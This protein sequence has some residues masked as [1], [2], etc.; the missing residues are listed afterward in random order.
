MSSTD[1]KS[2]SWTVSVAAEGEACPEGEPAARGESPWP[3][4]LGAETERAWFETICS[5]I[6]LGIV[7]VDVTTDGEFRFR[8]VN[9]A[10]A[11]LIGLPVAEIR[12]LAPRQLVPRIP[13]ELAES[14][15]AGFRR[16]SG[17]AGP[18]EFE[19]SWLVEDGWRCI[20]MRL[21][22]VF[23]RSGHV[24]RLI[25]RALDL[26]ERRTAERSLHVLSERLQLAAEAAHLGVWEFDL[27][28][29][30]IAWDARMQALYGAGVRQFPGTWRAWREFI[31]PE[32]VGRVESELQA[33]KR[34]PQ[35][36]ASVFR[37]RRAEGDVRHIRIAATVQRSPD[38]RPVRMVG[39]NA[40]VTA[41]QQAQV[42]LEQALARANQLARDATAATEAKSD[43]IASMSH[44][45]RTPMN[46]VIGMAGL[47][48]A[49]PLTPEQREFAE[50]IRASGDG[51]LALLNDLLDYAKIEAGRL[52]LEQRPFRV[53]DCMEASLDVLAARAAEK[54]LELV[55][56][57]EKGVPELVV[58][59]E[60]RLRQVVLNLLSNAVKFTMEGE[61]FL[62]LSLVGGTRE[63]ARLRCAV[64]DSGIGIPPDRMDRL[65]RSFSQVDASTTR[66][67][68]GTGLGLAISKRLVELMGGRIWVESTPGKGSIFYFEWETSAVAAADSEALAPGALTARRVLVVDDNATCARVLCQQAVAW[69]MVP[70]A[71]GSLRE[72]VGVL[73]R[74]E[75]FDL[76]LLDADLIRAAESEAAEFQ[77]LRASAELP[78]VLLVRPGEAR[79][80][81]VLQVAG[82]ATK[83]VKVR[84]LGH[85]LKELMQ[86]RAPP[87]PKPSAPGGD[88]PL[89]DEHPLTI[90]L[91]EDNPVNQRVATLILQRMGYRIDVAANGREAVEAV[92]ARE[93]DLVLMD[94]QMPEMDGL[95]ATRRILARAGRTM[96]RIVA[97]T[98]N[99]STDD[100]EKCL[101]AGMADFLAKPVR[102]AELRKVLQG[103]ARRQAPVAA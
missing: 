49:T 41:E 83:P 61:V 79:G 102:P 11:R 20:S 50:T 9:A 46:A 93:Y 42:E 54:K 63:S 38:G 94:L 57:V 19:Q 89:A 92:D 14:L 75:T 29:E 72:A 51:L 66:Q 47:L 100:R 78:V 97:M 4:E 44:E 17:S 26:T 101:A 88:A 21:A 59:D 64:H 40:D 28:Q 33:A 53:R 82:A 35:A 86:G 60:M 73:K 76:A 2:A 10:Y 6:D 56:S 18:L 95:E 3:D 52:E 87:A 90:L 81:E 39:I 7:V 77:R 23:D 65:F 30:R 98:A 13:L 37:I 1:L 58:G 36:W 43:F 62:S 25:G 16:G 74:G 24:A 84:P 12:G 103:T 27:G 69:G 32:D 15:Q 31:H 96:P 67:Y 5:N 22:P 68:G 8:D 80:A 34:G 70:R 91:A 45:I 48:L 55:C 85:L 71:A 99:V